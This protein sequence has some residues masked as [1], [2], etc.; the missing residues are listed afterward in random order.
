MESPRNIVIAKPLPARPGWVA[1]LG[2]AVL[3]LG[4]FYGLRNA[5]IA[6]TPAHTNALAPLSDAA[7]ATTLAVPAATASASSAVLGLAS[8]EV[9]VKANDTMD[10]IF[11]RLGLPLSDLASLRDNPAIRPVIDRLYPGDLLTIRHREGELVEMERQ[12]SPSERVHIRR[13]A[14]GFTHSV[15]E[16]PLETVTHTAHGVIDSSLFEAGANAGLT[17][18]TTLAVAEIFAWDI[19]FVLDVQPGDTFTVTYEKV[20]QDGEFLR[21]GP[22]LAVEF[23]NNGKI[24]RAVRYVD[25][26]GS[27]NYYTP[28]GESLRKAFL[29]APVEFSRISSRFSFARRHPVLNR[30]RAHKGVDYAAPIGTPIRAAGDGRVSFAGNKGGYGRVVELSHVNGISTVYGHMSRFA[31][32]LRS[33]Q[34]VSQGQVIGYVGMTGL[35]TGPHLHYEYRVRGQHKDPMRVIAPKAEPIA[36]DLRADFLAKTGPLVASLN[37]RPQATLATR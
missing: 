30:I 19:D 7:R 20:S 29:R 1:A 33:G 9:M 8:L 16:N 23:T 17:D 13:E 35:A 26:Q 11:R 22:V 31:S 2:F 28:E 14:A 27:A 3:G 34:R 25:P 15:A 6:S 36:A 21:D 24:H 4:A 5:P 10:R 32:G 18:N 37:L 12:L